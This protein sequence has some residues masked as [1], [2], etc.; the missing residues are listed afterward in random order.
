MS[1]KKKSKIRNSKPRPRVFVV[2]YD[3]DDL[4]QNHFRIGIP[5]PKPREDQES[6]AEPETPSDEEDQDEDD[7]RS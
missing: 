1:N 3:L 2:G 4:V 7:I 6:P 5:V